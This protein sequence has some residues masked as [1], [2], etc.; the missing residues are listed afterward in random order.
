MLAIS[1]VIPGR[2]SVCLTVLTG[3]YF[4]VLPF[5]ARDVEDLLLAIP[6]RLDC[7]RL[8]TRNPQSASGVRAFL[9]L[10]PLISVT[11]SPFSAALSEDLP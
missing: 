10:F 6:C 8:P 9:D 2:S 11:T 5:P 1:G 7:D 4:G 3:G